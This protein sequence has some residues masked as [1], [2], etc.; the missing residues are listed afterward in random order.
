MPPESLPPLPS[1]L[2]ELPTQAATPDTMDAEPSIEAA[3]EG[4]S[5][6]TT[7][8]LAPSVPSSVPGSGLPTPEGGTLSSQQG[9]PNM[10]NSASVASEPPQRQLTAAP[11]LTVASQDTPPGECRAQGTVEPGNMA[12]TGNLLSRPQAQPEAA[13]PDPDKPAAGQQ[14][15]LVQPCPLLQDLYKN[16]LVK[17]RE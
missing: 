13:P 4:S 17:F 2:P 9:G 12:Q 14:P 15:A 16:E 3:A 6:A 10:A 5:G 7:G 11:D 1:A 8:R